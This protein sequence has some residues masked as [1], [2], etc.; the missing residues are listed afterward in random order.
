MEKTGEKIK[1]RDGERFALHGGNERDCAFVNV[2]VCKCEC[3]KRKRE[4]GCVF[5]MPSF[6]GACT[7]TFV[8]YTA[9]ALQK[10]H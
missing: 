4:R 8:L 7:A 2:S 5:L 3:V 6:H 9:S 10:R 1:K